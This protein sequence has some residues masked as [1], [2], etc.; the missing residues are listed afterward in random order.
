MKQKVTRFAAMLAVLALVACGGNK[1]SG[2][3]AENGGSSS[4]IQPL[5]AVAEAVMLCE[6]VPLERSVRDQNIMEKISQKNH[7][8]Q[9]MEIKGELI[10][11]EMPTEGR[12]EFFVSIDSLLKVKAFQVGYGKQWSTLELETVIKIT[13]EGV[14]H[15]TKYFAVGFD[16]DEPVVTFQF[17]RNRVIE[18]DQYAEYYAVGDRVRLSREVK[19]D[20]ANAA[21]YARVKSFVVT[22]EEDP[23]YQDADEGMWTDREEYIKKYGK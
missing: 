20:P 18:G 6:G 9:S 14:P 8:L 15:N 11:I 22:V 7:Q 12:E 17:Q 1:Q 21:R 5:E 2:E 13:G 19:I 23:G 4:D 10:G 3:A 16:G